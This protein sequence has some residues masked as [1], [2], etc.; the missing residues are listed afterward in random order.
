LPKIG[1]VTCPNCE[2]E[3]LVD[4]EGK[5]TG[6]DKTPETKSSEHVGQN[7]KAVAISDLLEIFPPG[8]VVS[9]KASSWSTSAED[10][11]AGNPY[12][13]WMDKENEIHRL[14]WE[15]LNLCIEMVNKALEC[16]DNDE[17]TQFGGIARDLLD[18]AEHSCQFWWASRKPYWEINLIHLGLINQWR[19]IV[20]AYRSINKSGADGETKTTY[21]HKLIAARDVRNKIVDRLFIL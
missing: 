4:F 20:N 11:E 10:L 9:P 18:A 6:S 21:Y 16:G 17:S 3:I 19:V 12:P 14:Q 8:E 13:L 7:I 15:H 5:K 2:T 1:H